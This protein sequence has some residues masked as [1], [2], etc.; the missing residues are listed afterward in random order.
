MRTALISDLHGNDVSLRAVLAHV[1]AMRMAG[2]P[3]G[4]SLLRVAAV[5]LEV[6]KWG[7]HNIPPHESA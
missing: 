6:D 7:T 1:G 4:R 2:T 5:A 3:A